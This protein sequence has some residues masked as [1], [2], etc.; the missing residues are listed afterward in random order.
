MIHRIV[1][2]NI[3]AFMAIFSADTK[4]IVVKEFAYKK[5]TN[6]VLRVH[7]FYPPEWNNEDK[8]PVLLYFYNGVTT[9]ENLKSSIIP[10]DYLASRGIVAIRAELRHV[11]F[12]GVRLDK[13]FE[14]GRSAVRWIRRNAQ[15]LGVDPCR[16]ITSGASLSGHIAACTMIEKS[17]DD[18]DDDLS[19]S[20]IPQAMIL[21]CPGLDLTRPDNKMLKL[22]DSDLVLAKKLSPTQHL[23]HNSPPS[24][25]FYGTEDYLIDH[26]K[27]FWSKAEK[28]G[29]RAEKFIAEGGDH[30]CFG[31][32]PW[33]KR[34]FIETEKFL[35]S[36][37]FLK[38]NL[39]REDS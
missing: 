32:P 12:D 19:I 7:V 20:T 37:G 30:G 22:I 8:R 24:L 38:D 1:M 35:I 28:L 4:E 18:K 31:R 36:L 21:F 2:L 6:R 29:I 17:V 14:D 5:T 33:K 13:C 25:I 15:N 10:F 9:D 26:G 39:K 34:A 3:M 23:D 27:D 11:G 16:V